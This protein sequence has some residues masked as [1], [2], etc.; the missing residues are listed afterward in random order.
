MH[1]IVRVL[2]V[3]FCF[4]IEHSQ[5]ISSG[6]LVSQK[7]RPQTKAKKHLPLIYIWKNFTRFQTKKHNLPNNSKH[8]LKPKIPLTYSKSRNDTIKAQPV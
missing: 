7:S 1:S 6:T 4:V 2:Q 3:Y 8:H 5:E